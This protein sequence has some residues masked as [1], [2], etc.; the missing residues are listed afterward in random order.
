LDDIAGMIVKKNMISGAAT[1]F[2]GFLIALG[3]QFL[4]KVCDTQS[5]DVL[6]CF[7]MVRAAI[8][9]GILI[10]AF[11]VCLFFFPCPKVRQGLSIGVFL[12]GIVA[13]II[14]H[15]NFIGGCIA[16]EA[17]CR[18]LTLPALTVLGTLVILS[19]FLNLIYLEKKTK[20]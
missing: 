4:F 16:M 19:A 12:T 9:V 11:G 15:K 8:C 18:R 6:R 20:V 10:A 14:T 1:F 17:V 5:G 7:W 3:P 2:L 13:V